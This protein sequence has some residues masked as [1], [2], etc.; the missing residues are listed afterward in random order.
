MI[1]RRCLRVF[2]LPEDE[3]RKDRRFFESES[4]PRIAEIFMESMSD[5]SCPRI[6]SELFIV[7]F[8]F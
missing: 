8:Y 1:Q 5:V 6:D 2:G 7:S 3:I 4:F